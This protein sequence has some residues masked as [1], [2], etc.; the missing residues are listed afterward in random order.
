MECLLGTQAK[1]FAERSRGEVGTRIGYHIPKGP[2]AGLSLQ[3]EE[4]Q[5]AE[6]A[7]C[8]PHVSAPVFAPCLCTR[9]LNRPPIYY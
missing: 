8:V 4:P 9:S 6:A 5:F 2:P 1:E 3:S 7:R